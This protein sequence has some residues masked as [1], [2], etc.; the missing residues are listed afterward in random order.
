MILG[1][2]LKGC[3]GDAGSLYTVTRTDVTEI[4]ASKVF[5]YDWVALEIAIV[6]RDGKG[7]RAGKRKAS[8]RH[9]NCAI[10][11][12]SDSSINTERT[13]KSQE[14]NLQIRS[15]PEIQATRNE[16]IRNRKNAG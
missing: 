1:P 2:G 5:V 4:H 8:A 13:I 11:T 6:D 7:L 3:G 15:F 14:K 10:V 12:L 16:R 9:A